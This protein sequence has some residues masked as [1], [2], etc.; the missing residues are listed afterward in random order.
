MKNIK[1]YWWALLIAGGA[2]VLNRQ[3]IVGNLNAIRLGTNFTLD[4]FI[5]TA[6][7]YDNVPGE[8]EINNLRT[9]VQNVLQPFRDYLNRIRPAGT[10]ERRIVPSSGYRSPLVNAAVGGS[11]TSDHMTGRATDFS[12]PGMTPN[13]VAEALKKSGLPFDQLIIYPTHVHVSYKTPLRYMVMT[14]LNGLG[15]IDQYG[16][17]IDV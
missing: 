16:N 9:L 17:E 6:T 15:G 3:R 7:G 1:W 12:V 2:A 13:E 4:E 8:S 11:S 14:N 5:Q 10:P